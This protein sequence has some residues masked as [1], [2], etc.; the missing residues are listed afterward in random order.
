MAEYACLD[1]THLTG[2]FKSV[3]MSA[4][5]LDANNKLIILA[6]AVVPCEST[7]SWRFFLEHFKNAGL[8]INLKFFISDRDKG[9]INAVAHV[10]PNVPH[11]KCLRHLAENFKKNWKGCYYHIKTYGNGLYCFRL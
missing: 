1:A 7:D 2:R 3:L 9:L 5:T 11:A 10:F 6:Q 8:G 4:S